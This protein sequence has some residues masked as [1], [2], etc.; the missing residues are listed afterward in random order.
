MTREGTPGAATYVCMYVGRERE[1]R[2]RASGRASGRRGGRGQRAADRGPTINAADDAAGHSATMDDNPACRT[3]H[4]ARHTT[5][6]GR[7]WT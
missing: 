3:C 7:I 6:D 5:S 4:F 2:A 1:G